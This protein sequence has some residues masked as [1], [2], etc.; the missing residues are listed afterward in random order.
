MKVYNIR[1][2]LYQNE[3]N[4]FSPHNIVLWHD[5]QLSVTNNAAFMEGCVIMDYVSSAA[6]TMLATLARTALC[7]SPIFQFAKMC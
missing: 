5:V 6:Q 4:S 3:T 7:S 2:R 1:G